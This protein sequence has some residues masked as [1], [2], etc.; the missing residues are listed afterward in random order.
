[1]TNALKGITWGTFERL[2][3]G[4]Y[5]LDRA[6]NTKRME[7]LCLQQGDMSVADLHPISH[8]ITLPRQ[9]HSSAHFDRIFVGRLV[10][11]SFQPITK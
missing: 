6:R 10:V 5:F 7:F 11:S 4:K 9:E 1:M 8:L 3:L 2:F